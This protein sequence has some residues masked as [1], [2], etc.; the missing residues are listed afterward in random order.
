MSNLI[1][2][3]LIDLN[4]SCTF[5]ADSSSSA[6]RQP[7]PSKLRHATFIPFCVRKDTCSTIM[8]VNG[9]MTITMPDF[10][11][12]PCK[13]H[14]RSWY[15]ILFPYPVGKTLIQSCFLH[16]KFSVSNCLS[17]SPNFARANSSLASINWN[18]MW[19]SFRQTI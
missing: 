5:D 7:V 14:D 10:F 18:Y 6:E 16:K 12:P 4:V 19:I 15:M 13:N 1:Y 2:Q 11:L 3:Y 9:A 17:F 8:D